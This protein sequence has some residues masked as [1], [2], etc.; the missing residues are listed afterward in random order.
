M[1]SKVQA[2]DPDAEDVVWT[3]SEERIAEA[4]VTAFMEE[5]GIE[6]LE[7]LINRSR[8]DLAWFWGAVEQHLGVEWFEDYDQ[9]LDESEGIAWAK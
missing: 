8:E 9:V 1:V 4:N 2:P 5:H 7:E 6:D 3:P